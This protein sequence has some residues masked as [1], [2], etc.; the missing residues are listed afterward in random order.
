[1][2]NRATEKTP[3]WRRDRCGN[4]VCNAC[5]LFAK[6]TGRSRPLSLK[7]DAIKSRLR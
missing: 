4:V 3:L 1:C 7:T 5:A 6:A 2:S